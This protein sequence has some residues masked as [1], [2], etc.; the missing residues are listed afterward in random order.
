MQATQRPL[1]SPMIDADDTKAIITPMT[2]AD[3]TN[4][5]NDTDD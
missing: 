1:I 3:Y 2:D 5:I 4:V